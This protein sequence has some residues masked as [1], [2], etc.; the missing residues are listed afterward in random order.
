MDPKPDLVHATSYERR[1]LSRNT[2][3]QPSSSS[4]PPI[5]TVSERVGPESDANATSPVDRPA[6]MGPQYLACFA[7]TLGSFVMGTAIGWSGPALSL[8]TLTNGTDPFDENRERR[9]EISLM[10]QSLIA[11]LM[12]LGALLGGKIEKR[13]SN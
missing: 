13:P 2:M 1:L 7:A 5:G 10:D 4:Y 12:P 6:K 8:L 9:F 3:S 11:S